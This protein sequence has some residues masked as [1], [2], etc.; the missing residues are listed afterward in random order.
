MFHDAIGYSPSKGGGGADGSIIVFAD[1]ET[2][3]PANNGIDEI[4][5]A[6]KKFMIDYNVTL[7]PGDFI[8]LAG[9]VGVAN[10]RGAPRL[11]FFLGRPPPTAASPPGLVPEP[12]DSVNS[13]LERFSDVGFSSD[14]V[15]ALMASHSIAAADHVDPSVPGSPLDSTPDTFD[16]QFYIEVQLRGTTYPGAGNNT[17]EVP[18]PVQGEMRIQSDH[19]IARDARTA[20]HWRSFVGDQA[21]MQSEFQAAMDKLSTLGQDRNQL[22]D[23]S[24]VI[25]DPPSLSA[26]PHLPA[27]LSMNDIEQAC[28]SAPFPSLAAEPGPATSVPPV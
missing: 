19:E 20:C 11:K 17:G 7:S 16:T 18:S 10:C 26:N 6:Q 5:N 8:Q 2:K 4:V 23:C 25:P 21:K 22:I 13:I 24:E 3:F 9:A 27:G 14:E 28:N 15:V 1:I 12:Q